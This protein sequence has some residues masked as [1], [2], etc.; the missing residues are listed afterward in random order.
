MLSNLR[1]NQ[2]TNEAENRQKIK[3]NQSQ[4]KTYWFLSKKS[5]YIVYIL[6]YCRLQSR[7]RRISQEGGGEG[8]AFWKFYTTE[9]E[10]DPNFH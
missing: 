9:N 6:L 5:E 4:F 8:R 2:K 1:T 7:R 3:N 10:L